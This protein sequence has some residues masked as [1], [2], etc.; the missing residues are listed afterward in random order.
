MTPDVWDGKDRRRV[1][2]YSAHQATFETVLRFIEGVICG[3]LCGLIALA[4][5]VH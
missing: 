2:F 5:Y 1:N 4:F 3:F